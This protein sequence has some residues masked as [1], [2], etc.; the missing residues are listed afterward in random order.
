MDFMDFDVGLSEAASNKIF[1]H[2]VQEKAQ[3]KFVMQSGNIILQSYGFN[4]K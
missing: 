2:H 1:A 4:L 3:D